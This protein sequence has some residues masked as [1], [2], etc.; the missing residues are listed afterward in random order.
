MN[1]SERNAYVRAALAMQG[2]TFDD[3]RIADIIRQFERIESIAA[4]LLAADLPVDAE[5]A[6]AFRP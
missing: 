5:P 1:D 6:P 4:I 3:A 2:Y